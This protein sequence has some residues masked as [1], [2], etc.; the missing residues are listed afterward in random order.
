MTRSAEYWQSRAN[1]FCV[2]QAKFSRER[3]AAYQAGS[4]DAIRRVKAAYDRAFKNIEKEFC[5]VPQN[6][7]A[8]ADVTRTFE[9]H[10]GPEALD[11]NT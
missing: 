3:E 11:A 4:E 6:S 10:G 1:E 9:R 7:K 8:I 5:L 2:N